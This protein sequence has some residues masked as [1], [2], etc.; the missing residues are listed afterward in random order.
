MKNKV[1]RRWVSGLTAAFL[2]LM[3]GLG[4]AAEKTANPALFGYSGLLNVPTADVLGPHDYY[5]GVRYFPLNS[6]L[7]GV[8]T[9]SFLDDFE[10]GLVFGVPPANG[11]SALAASLKYRVI[12][13]NDGSPLSMAVGATLLGL[14][15]SL[16]YVPG[17]NAYISLSRG[18]DWSGSRLFNVHG[19]FMG[20]L[21]GARIFAGV[22]VPI[23][24][25]A[26]IESEYLGVING[27]Q[28][29]NFGLV[30]YPHPDVSI[31]LASMQRPGVPQNFWDR[32]FVLGVAY[33]GDWNQWLP[34]SNPSTQPGPSA[35]TQPSAQPT[36]QA[37]LR[38]A[39]REKG[40]IRIRVIDRE[41]ITALDRAKVELSQAATGLRFSAQTDVNGEVTFE[42][43]PIGNYQVRAQREGWNPE[44]R[45][46]SVQERLETF[47]EIPLTGQEGVILGE[48]EA[49]SGELD[50]NLEIVIRDLAGQV[51]RRSQLK[52]QNYRLERIPPGRY[53]LLV[54]RGN[55]ERLRLGIQVKGN[56]ESRYDLT[57][58][59][60]AQPSVQP[61]TS[62][63]TAP[64][65]VMA[66]VTG[67]VKDKTGKPLTGVRVELKND[68]LLILT[69]SNPEGQ[70]TFRD[71]P[72]GIYRLSL[73]KEGFK[74]R[75]FQL[76]ITESK[77]LEYNF[78]L[79]QAKP[80]DSE[81]E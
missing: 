7:S 70:Y 17:S 32:D 81:K 3:P 46:I 75:A 43:I 31:E 71:I 55:Q 10:A 44:V 48:L 34:T 2:S 54:F 21:Q 58:P 60:L 4:F 33:R 19:G 53:T 22:D 14:E 1:V 39:A 24:D 62:P 6:G 12:D 65:E 52:G 66:Q 9:V 23:L 38:P 49:A 41:R 28:A 77:E 35:S 50:S 13:Q 73:S 36:P 47:L 42:H 18:F 8:T 67:V 80:A 45:L 30:I 27:F 64:K 61:S 79:D 74:P 20:G 63:S 25:V 26:R 16:S 29:L 68:D 11:F 76:T 5:G 72:R 15:D 69:L 78:E 37:S 51:V 59:P 56:E 40:D 57:L